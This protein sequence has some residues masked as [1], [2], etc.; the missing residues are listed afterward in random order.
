MMTVA[1]QYCPVC[2]NGMFPVNL[3]SGDTIQ[4]TCVDKH[5]MV[6]FMLVVTHVPPRSTEGGE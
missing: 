2:G 5:E 1:V 6:S 4:I 3:A